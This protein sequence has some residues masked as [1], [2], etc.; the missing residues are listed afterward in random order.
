MF[1]SH[2]LC[3]IKLLEADFQIC[4]G[5]ILAPIWKER[6]LRASEF[7]HSQHTEHLV[8]VVSIFYQGTLPC[9]N[10]YLCIL[11]F[12]EILRPRSYAHIDVFQGAFPVEPTGKVR[13]ALKVHRS[14]IFKESTCNLMILRNFQ[15]RHKFLV[16][17]IYN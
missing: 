13:Q 10:I 2:Y 17:F 6:A 8:S 9:T 1:E 5:D 16:S 15:C 12:W 11:A 7:G 3:S 14:G 4:D